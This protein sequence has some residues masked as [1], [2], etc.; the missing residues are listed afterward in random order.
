MKSNTLLLTALIAAF[1]PCLLQAQNALPNLKNAK[2][3]V[4][5]AVSEVKITY[6]LSDSDNEKMEVSLALVGP[7]GEI[8]NVSGATGDIGYPVLTGNKKTIVWQYPDSLNKT[9]KQYK[10]RLVADDRQKTDIAALV[11]AI[12]T[13]P[14]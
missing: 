7:H 5:K 14:M 4:S 11:K 8:M 12:D 9:I 3:K 2:A 10:L 6:D 13:I 1:I